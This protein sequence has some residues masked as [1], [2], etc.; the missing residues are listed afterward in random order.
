MMRVTE[1]NFEGFTRHKSP[2]FPF[3]PQI[4]AYSEASEFVAG[5]IIIGHTTSASL[6]A[7]PLSTLTFF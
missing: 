4:N 5:A 1:T 3:P 7:T 6:V 2:I